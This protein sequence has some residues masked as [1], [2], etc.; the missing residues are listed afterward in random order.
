MVALLPAA[1]LIQLLQKQAKPI[2]SSQGIRYNQVTPCQAT[3]PT[4]QSTQQPHRQVG[5][6]EFLTI[7]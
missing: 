5:E 7:G 2:D 6:T 4:L 3:Q 1:R